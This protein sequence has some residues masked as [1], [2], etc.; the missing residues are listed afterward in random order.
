V[1]VYLIIWPVKTTV[2]MVPCRRYVESQ[3]A[4]LSRYVFSVIQRHGSIVNA[5][6]H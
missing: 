6:F 3:C 5:W 4:Y 1:G 2:T